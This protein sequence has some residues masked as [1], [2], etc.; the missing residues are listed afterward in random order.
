VV[1]LAGLCK[2]RIHA[3]A[4]LSEPQSGDT[5]NPLEYSGAT[6]RVSQVKRDD[7]PVSGD[8][9]RSQPSGGSKRA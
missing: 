8:K 6:P 2:N 4:K 3:N 1:A 9:G 5:G 7:S